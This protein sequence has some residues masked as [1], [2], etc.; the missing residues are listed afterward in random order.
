VS[1]QPEAEAVA[2]AQPDRVVMVAFGEAPRLMADVIAGGYPP[3]RIVGLDGF[4]VPSIASQAFPGDPAA[5][6]GFTV[7]ATAGDRA[8]LDRLAA[9]PSSDDQ[10]AYGAQAYDCAITMALAAAE[11]GSTDAANIT[12]HVRS[13]TAGGR[14]CSSYADC[15]ALLAQGEDID[16]DGA[17]GGIAIDEAG[18]IT[19][20]RFVTSVLRSGELREVSTTDIDLTAIDVDAIHESAVLAARIQQLLRILGYLE[21]DPTGVFDQATIDAIKALQRDLGLPETGTFDEATE[22]ALRDR[23]GVLAAGLT[24]SVADIQRAL[25]EAG[26][27]DGPIDG[28]VSAATIEAV[29][30]LQRELG[31]PET[32]FIDGATLRAIYARGAAGTQEPPDTEPPATDA[33]V[34]EPPATDPP[35]TEAPATDPPP[36]Q[37]PATQPPA[38]QPPATE[39]PATE[40]PAT[41]P[42]A[43]EPVETEPPATEPPATEPPATEPPDTEPPATEPPEPAPVDMFAVLAADPQFSRLVD[44]LRAAGYDRDLAQPGR[45]TFFAPTNAAFASLPPTDELLGDPDRLSAVLAFHLV[46][47]AIALDALVPGP[48]TTVHGADVQVGT[49]G[50]AV[51]VGGARIV[52][53]GLTASNGIV[54]A[55]DQVLTPPE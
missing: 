55:I 54:H 8:L 26:F 49:D 9:V 28:R 19:S 44:L 36:T 13:V 7:I 43:T 52:A 23:A 21:G 6:D 10:L 15:A 38:T 29:R 35:P 24:A 1:F 30:A 34:T 37:P 47:G 14:T 31:V 5:A 50:G 51:T 4:F 46:E 40:P 22:Q 25:A 48:L 3:E 27:Y 39:P 45:L 53:P 2:A 18:D 16:F 41:E 20:A 32:G 42:P 12:A 11:A 17:T 33:P